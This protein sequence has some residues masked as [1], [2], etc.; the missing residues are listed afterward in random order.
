MHHRQPTYSDNSYIPA[1][2]PA[3]EIFKF[4]GPSAGPRKIRQA[5]APAVRDGFLLSGHNFETCTGSHRAEFPQLIM[6]LEA[7]C[8]Y[9]NKW[10]FPLS[11]MHRG[12]VGGSRGNKRIRHHGE[13]G[14]METAVRA[15]IRSITGRGARI[16]LA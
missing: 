6:S 10:V 5:F 7:A 14:S 8:I 12:P 3:T 13:R 11:A 15:I 1:R 9:P 4:D 2:V 16:L